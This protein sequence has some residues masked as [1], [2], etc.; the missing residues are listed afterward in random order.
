[1]GHA[2]LTYRSFARF[3]E[4]EF[5]SDLSNAPFDKVYNHTDP[6]A[7]LATWYSVF[8]KVLDK[9]VLLKKEENQILLQTCVADIGNTGCNALQRLSS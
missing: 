2:R 5:L 6:D 4:S 7:A 8:L 3:D 1:M 9:H